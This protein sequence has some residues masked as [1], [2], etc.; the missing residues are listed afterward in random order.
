MNTIFKP[1]NLKLNITYIIS[2]VNKAL[3]FEWISTY[4]N[5]ND[6]N[7]NFILLNPGDSELEEFLK[8]NKIKVDRIKYN[9]K[10][11]ILKCIFKTYSLLK[12]K[13]NLSSSHTSI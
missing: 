1:P 11:D 12:K 3:A 13:Q 6:F 2:N 9:G 10:K 5:K 7:L 4:L 8:S